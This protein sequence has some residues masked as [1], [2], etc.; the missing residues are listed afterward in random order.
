MDRDAVLKQMGVGDELRNSGEFTSF[1]GTL[2][3]EADEMHAF[4]GLRCASQTRPFAEN[5]GDELPFP[6]HPQPG[7]GHIFAAQPYVNAVE[8]VTAPQERAK[9]NQNRMP[10]ICGRR[11]FVRAAVHFALLANALDRFDSFP[12]DRLPLVSCV[13]REVPASPLNSVLIDPGGRRLFCG[14]RF[15][16][17]HHLHSPPLAAGGK[18]EVDGRFRFARHFVKRNDALTIQSVTVPQLKKSSLIRA[19]QTRVGGDAIEK[20]LR[21]GNAVQVV[22]DDFH[23]IGFGACERVKKIGFFLRH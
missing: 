3:H 7:I 4:T 23:E 18:A 12:F 14:L 5:T 6:V 15:G 19:F 10:R 13:T 17:L 9:I 11:E 20:R 22:N 8:F 21:P 2:A 1:V 16:E